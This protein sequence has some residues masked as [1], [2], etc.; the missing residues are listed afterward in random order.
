MAVPELVIVPARPGI[1]QAC[2]VE[3][4]VRT[5]A[6]GRTVLPVFSS[7]AALVQELG[8]CQPWVCV[9][10]RLAEE[11][12]H[13]ARLAHVVLDPV[14]GTSGQRWAAADLRASSE[15]AAIHE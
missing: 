4:E 5:Q 2:P 11:A 3:F 15:E 8:R 10:W 6:D 7:V 12:A 14:V 9:P 13:Q 1:G